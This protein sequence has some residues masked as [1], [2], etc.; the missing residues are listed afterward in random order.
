MRA[1]ALHSRTGPLRRYDVVV[2]CGVASPRFVWRCGV[3]IAL[4][5]VCNVSRQRDGRHKVAPA[6]EAVQIKG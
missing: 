4:H 2:A 6:G 1:Y 3:G 5:R